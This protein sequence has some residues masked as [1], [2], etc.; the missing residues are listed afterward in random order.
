MKLHQAT[1]LLALAI[2][3][4]LALADLAQAQSAGALAQAVSGNYREA[5]QKV[6]DL[7]K[8]RPDPK[9]LTPKVG[10]L[11]EETI[12]K[13]VALGRKVAALDEK[14]QKQA[15]A[16]VAQA[17]GRVPGDLF[18]TY[19]QGQQFYSQKDAALGKLIKDFNIITQ[20]AFFP[21]LKKQDPKEAE[22]LGIQ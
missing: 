1:M 22:R 5:L 12:Q 19:S 3:S 20:Y 7:M 16:K 14:G 21:L 8:D 13:M 17:F 15:E 4:T 6:T 18:K 10:A 9:D 11:R 2:L